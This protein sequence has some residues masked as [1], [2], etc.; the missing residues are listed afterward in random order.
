MLLIFVG[1]VANFPEPMDEDGARQ[2]VARLA[3]VKLTVR[4]PAQ[5]RVLEPIK[6]EQGALEPTQF[7]QCRGH[8]VLSRV[9][10]QL[11]HDQGSRHRAVRIEAATRKISAQWVRISATL[12]R[13]AI[14]GP[15]VG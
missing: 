9:G 4:L 12:M 6:R 5:S 7:T 2:A 15:S 3:L 14:S 13:P 8:T 10:G 11:A 1:A